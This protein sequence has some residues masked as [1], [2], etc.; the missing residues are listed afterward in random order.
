M[1]GTVLRAEKLTEAPPSHRAWRFAGFTLDADAQRLTGRRGEELRLRPQTLRV[2]EQL[3]RR[4]NGIVTKEELFAT[5]WAGLV[6]TD[7][8]LVQCVS[9]L[10]LALGDETQQLIRT[11]PRRGYMLCAEVGAVGAASKPLARV[12]GR[13]WVALASLAAVVALSVGYWALR[14]PPMP[15]GAP[16]ASIAVLPFTSLGE[17]ADD[18]LSLGLADALITRLSAIDRLVVRPT[19]AILRYRKGV[20][21]QAAGRELAVDYVLDSRLQRGDG[22]LRITFQLVA[23]ADGSTRWSDQ[24]EA[25]DTGLFQVQDTIAERV[26]SSMLARLS[27]ED[28]RLL[29]RRDTDNPESHLAYLRGRH[30]W[31][32]RTEAGLTASIAEFKRAI[33]LDPSNATAHAGLADAYN[34]L[35]AY[36]SADPQQAFTAA[37]ASALQALAINPELAEAHASLAFAR[38]HQDRDWPEAEREYRTAIALAPQYATARQWLALAH[39]AQGRSAQAIEEA[40]RALACDPLSLIINT[41]LGRHFYYARRY[42]EAIAQ[43]RATIDLDPDFPRAHVELARAYKQ[44]GMHD[45]AVAEM[46]R[47]VQ[48]SQRSATALAELASA[49]AAQGDRDHA[50]V[51]LDELEQTARTTHVSPYHFAVVWSALGDSRRALAAL[52]AADAERFNWTVF[53]NVEPEFDALRGEP[54]FAALVQRLRVADGRAAR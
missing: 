50:R 49:Y 51:L 21:P 38:A 45:L 11:M 3:V 54:A 2:L 48:L 1:S 33:A 26:A 31:A 7:D 42:D 37:K 10:R 30:F 19:S 17:G 36:G 40:R 16:V 39:A 34:L 32:K 13:L 8:S 47:A 43:L 25:P 27:S 44:K 4:A 5:V 29:R 28:R 12:A 14:T 20:D 41:D 53:A 35:A 23:I 22:R 24:V 52:E 6:V 46:T 9:E 15:S 18:P